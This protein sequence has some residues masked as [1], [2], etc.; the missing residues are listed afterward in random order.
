MIVVEGAVR[1]EPGDIEAARPAMEKMIRSSRAETGCIDYAY[2]LDLID[3]G[4]VRVSERWAD[5][6][7]LKA[8]LATPHMAE[9]R[10]ALA[11]LGLRDRSLRVYEAE[12]EDL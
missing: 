5:R 4:L 7:A 6:A 2:A 8:H 10:A 3:P 9:W 12:P 11:G 1:I